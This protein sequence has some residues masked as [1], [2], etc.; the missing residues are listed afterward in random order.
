MKFIFKITEVNRELLIKAPYAAL[1][2]NLTILINHSLFFNEEEISLLELALYIAGWLNDLKHNIFTNFD[3]SSDEY[4]ENPVLCFT[5]IDNQHY[6]INSAWV[7][8]YPDNLL[9]LEEIV[10]CFTT[11]LKELN[12]VIQQEYGVT[13]ADIPFFKIITSPKAV[14]AKSMWSHLTSM[15]KKARAKLIYPA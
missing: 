10:H 14:P 3:Y 1:D 7:K 2:G 13:F 4:E 8:Q 5:K 6:A 12:S 15:L 9:S 11:F